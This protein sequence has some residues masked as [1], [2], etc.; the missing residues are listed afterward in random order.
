MSERVRFTITSESARSD[1][2][3]HLGSV[4]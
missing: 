1:P 2:S 3:N 4:G